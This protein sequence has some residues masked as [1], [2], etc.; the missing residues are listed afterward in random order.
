MR[1]LKDVPPPG[2]QRAD[3][4]TFSAA[5]LTNI[6]HALEINLYGALVNPESSEGTWWGWSDEA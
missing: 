1:R 3:P 5:F 2:E 4:D 6:I